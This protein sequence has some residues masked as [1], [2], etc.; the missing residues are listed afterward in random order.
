[1]ILPVLSSCGFCYILHFTFYTLVLHFTF[2]LQFLY[3]SVDASRHCRCRSL[4][5]VELPFYSS[6]CRVAFLLHC[7]YI[8]CRVA[9]SF[10]VIL[11]VA[12]P[13][14]VD[15]ISCQFQLILHFAVPFALKLQFCQSSSASCRFYL[16]SSS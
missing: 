4:P 11:P 5:V 7:R 15:R 10:T 14:V 3:S 13:A 9:L 2:Q 8:H 12:L 16:L 1:M 6:S